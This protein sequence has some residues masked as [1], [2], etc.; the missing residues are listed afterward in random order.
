MGRQKYGVRIDGV[1][2][3]GEWLVRE[4]REHNMTCE[5]FAGLLKT[6]RQTITKYA[7]KKARPSYI[8]VVAICYIFNRNPDAIWQLVEEDWA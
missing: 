3:F 1:G 5:E 7:T 2:H 6:T 8:T 4:L